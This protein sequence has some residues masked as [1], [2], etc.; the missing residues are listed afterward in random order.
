MVRAFIAVLA[1]L[2]LVGAVSAQNQA[3]PGTGA[4]PGAPIVK[5][6]AK[7]QPPK[8]K[9]ATTAIVAAEKGPCRLGV[10]PAV[11]DKFVVQKIGFTIFNNEFTEVPIDAWG[12]DEIVVARVRAAAGE[13]TAVRRLAYAKGTFTPYEHPGPA[14][15]RIP[16]N[17]LTAIVR[18]IAANTGCERY[19]AITKLEGVLD[20]TNQTLLGIGILNH[21]TSLLSRTNLFVNISVTVFDGQTFAIHRNPPASLGAVLAGALQMTAMRGPHREL[22]NA[23][24]P[25]NAADAVNSSTLRDGTRT[26][27]TETLDKALP[28]IL[29]P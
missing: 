5:P 18:Q 17:E 3:A 21:G 2:C 12:L 8:A 28:A 23:Q 7:K 4:A 9:A 1:L 22:D 29:A 19:V 26:L 20:G 16:Q 11:G 15:F 13:G 6:A 14:L 24:F 27:L 25:A 10:I